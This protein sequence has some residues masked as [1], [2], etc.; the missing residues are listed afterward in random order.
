MSIASKLSAGLFAAAWVCSLAAAEVISIKEPADFTVPKRL[1]KEGESLALKGNAILFSART[2]VLDPAKK[3]KI[4]GDFRLK[5][6]EISGR[7]FLGYAPY[8]AQGKPISP[9]AVNATSKSD[10]EIA[11]AAKKGDKVIFVKDASKWNMKTPYGYIVFN[12]KEDYSD[13]PNRDLIGIPKDGIKQSGDVWEI[14]L[15]TP[16][17]NDRAAGVKVRQ[18]LGAGTFIY[19]SGSVQVRQGWVTRTGILSGVAKSGSP[20]NKLWAGTASV[21]VLVMVLGGKT[22]DVLEMKNIKVEEVK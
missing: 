8:D 13:L 5:E 16:L 4:S 9:A 12:T 19:N 20:T 22:T 21:R 17:T 15:K 18:H 14:T 1:S 11:R 3:Y 2:L 10:T 6:G 7:V